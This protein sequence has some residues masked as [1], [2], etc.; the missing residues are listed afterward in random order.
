MKSIKNNQ[1]R[2]RRKYVLWT[3]RI[4]ERKKG[5]SYRK[6]IFTSGKTWGRTKTALA[7]QHSLEFNLSV[8]G[9]RD[10][11]VVRVLSILLLLILIVA[12]YV[13]L[14]QVIRWKLFTRQLRIMALEWNA[15]TTTLSLQKIL[16]KLM[17]FII[18]GPGPKGH[19]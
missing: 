7:T 3:G 12:V 18:K 6:T 13:Y 5:E 10:T 4:I 9:S 2:I 8:L 11:F 19:H 17:H 15:I 16:Y 14:Y 1:R